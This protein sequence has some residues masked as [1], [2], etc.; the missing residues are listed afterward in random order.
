MGPDRTVP[1]QPPAPPD[2]V[3]SPPRLTNYPPSDIA[4]AR[5]FGPTVAPQPLDRN[6]RVEGDL[7]ILLKADALT[8]TAT[9]DK[10]GKIRL[11]C[12]AWAEPHVLLPGQVLELR[13]QAGQ[14]VL[15]RRAERDK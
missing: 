4:N 10:V 14:V 11:N 8:V 5:A 7:Q 12:S 6:K 2:G 15:V 3:V 13:W 1:P 9:A